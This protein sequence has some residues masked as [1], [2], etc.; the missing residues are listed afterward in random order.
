MLIHLLMDLPTLI[1]ISVFSAFAYYLSRLN[2]EIETIWHSMDE[3]HNSNNVVGAQRMPRSNMMSSSEQINERILQ[4][5][6]TQIR[7]NTT[8]FAKMFYIIANLLLV[9]FYIVCFA[10]CKYTQQHIRSI[11]LTI[12]FCSYH[13]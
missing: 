2:M 8:S 4:L 6:G 13:Y 9:I 3:S 7:E 10:K 12:L 1:L 5:Q 11:N